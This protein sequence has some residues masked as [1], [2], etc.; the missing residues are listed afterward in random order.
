MRRMGVDMVFDRIVNAVLVCGMEACLLHYFRRDGKWDFQTGF[1]ALR[2]FT[3][4]S[5]VLCAVGA[6]AILL[7]PSDVLPFGVWLLKYLG[8]AAVTVTLLTVLLFLGPT[9]GYKLLFQGQDLYLHLIAPLLAILSFCFMERDHTLT[10]GW[11]L[12]GLIPMLL[13]GVFYLWQVVLR[14]PAGWEDFYGY[15]KNGKWPVSFALMVVGTF[16]LCMLL[17]LLT[18]IAV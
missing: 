2:Y 7:T 5:N 8:T 6:L 14:K 16:L 11:S 10:F 17:L 18:K 1:R 9:L 3:V 12:L 13:Y 15:N 4:L